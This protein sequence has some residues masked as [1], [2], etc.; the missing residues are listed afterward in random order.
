MNILRLLRSEKGAAT[1]ELVILIPF[2]VAAM[3]IFISL[4]DAFRT[5]SLSL[6]ASYTV[7][8]HLSRKETIIEDDDIDELGDLFAFLAKSTEDTAVRVTV[9]EMELDPVTDTPVL[10]WKYSRSTNTALVA[11]TTTV[12]DV[13]SHV[14]KLALGKRIYITEAYT[15]WTPFYG[16]G[17][18]PA[19]RMY[20]VAATPPRF[21]AP[22]TRPEQDAVDAAT[23]NPDVDPAEEGGT[24]MAAAE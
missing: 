9:L 11:E 22:L 21:S 13:R 23:A 14:P 17:V 5:A 20:H 10:A 4:W 12:D 18:M 3:A 19:K 15:D 16:P 6:Y 8:D 24:D 2:L 7:A 1:V